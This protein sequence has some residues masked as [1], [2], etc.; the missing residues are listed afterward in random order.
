MLNAGS[1][2]LP[3]SARATTGN[4][5]DRSDEYAELRR[6]LAAIAGDVKSIV[7]TRAA[8]V[9]QLATDTAEAGLDATRETIRD[10]PVTSIAV[11]AIL[12][13]A[14]AIALTPAP[15]RPSL[16]AR[17]GNFGSHYVPDVTRADLND[18]ARHLQRSA[19][20]AVQGSPLAAAFERVV[21]SVSSIDPK[22]SLT[23]ALEKA[24]AWL[25]S[26]RASMGGK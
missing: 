26:L 8:Q 10:Y 16:A 12:G 23:P 6:E 14:L 2:E 9:Q 20:Q 22:S 11:A 4:N 19:S 3:K 15:R 25:S 17:I 5:H 21:D 18:M 24:G 7:E 13:A 1:S